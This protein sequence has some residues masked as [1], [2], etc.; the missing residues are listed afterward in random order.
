MAPPFGMKMDPN[1]ISIDDI[2]NG[3]KNSPYPHVYV[4]FCNYGNKSRILPISSDINMK[5]ERELEV[6]FTFNGKG[7]APDVAYIIYYFYTD[8]N[9]V[10]NMPKNASYTYLTTSYLCL[11]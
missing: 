4:N 8:T 7:S 9:M 11:G 10:L 6:K 3:G 1:K 5:E 2:Q